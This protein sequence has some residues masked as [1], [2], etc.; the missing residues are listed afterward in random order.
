MPRPLQ[1]LPALTALLS[2]SCC[3]IQ[4]I[5]NLFSISCAGFAVLTPYRSLLGSITIGLL[6]YNL[7]NKGLKSRQAWLSLAISLVLMISPDIVKWVNQSAVTPAAGMIYSYRIHLDGLGCEAC[8]NRIRNTL[9][10]VDWIYQTRVF[11]ENQTA[12]V[13]TF[14]EC[15]DGIIV[16][17]IKA[18]DAKYDAQVLDSW[19]GLHEFISVTK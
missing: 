19:V 2:S 15:R 8:A 7:Y 12:V 9:N 16:E 4:L 17:M 10:A 1:V 11:F 3:V 14:N 6:S 18:I 5:L 13:Q